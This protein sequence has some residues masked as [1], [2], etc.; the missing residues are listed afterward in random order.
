MHCRMFG[1]IPRQSTQLAQPKMSLHL[2]KCSVRAE[3]FLVKNTCSRHVDTGSPRGNYG[4]R[5]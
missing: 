5:A 3:L 4:E 2:T 1:S